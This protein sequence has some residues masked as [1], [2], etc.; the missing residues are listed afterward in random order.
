MK[1]VSESLNELQDFNKQQD[2]LGSLGIG[3]REIIKKWLDEMNIQDYTINDDLTIDG[4]LIYLQNKNIIKLPDYIKFNVV[5]VRFD[6]G[7]C[8]LTTMIGCPRRVIGNFLADHNNLTSLDH[9]P[10]IVKGD[11]FINDN[12]VE[13]NKHDILNV[14]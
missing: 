12:D 9:C 5:K 4:T 1:L 8:N 2:A 3:K 11:F 14:C 7:Y 6:I 13:F 10:I